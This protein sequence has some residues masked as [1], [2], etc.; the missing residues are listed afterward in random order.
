LRQHVVVCCFLSTRMNCCGDPTG[1]SDR[2]SGD[3]LYVFESNFLT[4]NFLEDL[5]HEFPQGVHVTLV[6]DAHATRQVSHTPCT[7][8]FT[9]APCPRL[10]VP[11]Y[12]C[13][14][15]RN[16]I[17]LLQDVDL[18]NLQRRPLDPIA[19]SSLVEH[20]LPKSRSFNPHT[21]WEPYGDYVVS[22]S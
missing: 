7:F 18:V 21:S 11:L 12:N 16:G 13:G 1:A 20:Y 2:R 8:K 17:H 9:S 10:A 5:H 14:S 6:S 19:S 15:H 4:S 22:I 3:L